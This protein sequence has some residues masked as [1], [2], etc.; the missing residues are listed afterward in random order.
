[1]TS[2]L[3]Q[4]YRCLRCGVGRAISAVEQQTM[5]NLC[6]PPPSMSSS[7]VTLSECL[8]VSLLSDPKIDFRLDGLALHRGPCHRH[9]AAVVQCFRFAAPLPRFL[10]FS[11]GRWSGLRTKITTRVNLP[12]ELDISPWVDRASWGSAP[13]PTFELGGLVRH[14]GSSQA[15]GHYT[16]TVRAGT[17]FVYVD[18]R[19]CGGQRSTTYANLDTDEGH[20][21]VAVYFNRHWAAPDIPASRKRKGA[22]VASDG[23]SGRSLSGKRVAVD[24]SGSITLRRGSRQRSRSSRVDRDINS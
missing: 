22:S 24:P 9:E 17:D 7:V 1:V 15:V 18:D 13:T 11:F 23:R 6:I 20:V 8:D 14:H 3:R 5:L 16:A 10:V 12:P 21:F 2:L 19:K 4:W